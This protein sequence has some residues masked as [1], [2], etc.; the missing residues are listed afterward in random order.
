M[1]LI[2]IALALLTEAG[3]AYPIPPQPLRWL[4]RDADLVVIA[5]PG[6]TVP[7]DHG[8]ETWRN[9]KVSLAVQRVLKGSCGEEITV[10]YTPGMVCPAPDRYPPGQTILALLKWNRELQGYVARGLSYAT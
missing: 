1:T 2:A 4:Y 7:A 6:E 5:T 10:F 9:G 3:T 8:S